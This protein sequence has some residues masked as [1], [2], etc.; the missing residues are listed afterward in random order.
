MTSL[1]DA[2]ETLRGVVAKNKELVAE[3]ERALTSLEALFRLDLGSLITSV[4]N[5]SKE[6]G[7]FLSFKSGF[8]K[9]TVRKTLK[10]QVL[11][12]VNSIGDEEF[13][14]ASVDE[15]LQS[16]GINV[17]GKYP[18]A[19]ISILLSQLEN[20]KIVTKT[21]VGKGNV[22]HRYKRVVKEDENGGI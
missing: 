10:E 14:V 22:P 5:S 17:N 1:S 2:I 12:A 20:D 4:G 11:E 3:Q 8:G 7:E 19:R 18:R 21:F 16:Q 9:S 15:T 13:S 6:K